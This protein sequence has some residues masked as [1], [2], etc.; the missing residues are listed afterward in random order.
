MNTN[1]AGETHRKLA[2]CFQQDSAFVVFH[3]IPLQRKDSFK[4]R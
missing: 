3:A 2:I 4:Y 1:V